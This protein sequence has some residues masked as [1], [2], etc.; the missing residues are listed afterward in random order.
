MLVL[1]LIVILLAVTGTLAFVLKVAL[2][3]A[4]GL[5]LGIALAG[6][7]LAW[8]VRRMLF[9]DRPRWRRVRGPSSTIEVLDRDRR[10]RDI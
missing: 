3:V 1:L 10:P 9:G 6:A 8:R 4:L 2:G 5:F 7:L